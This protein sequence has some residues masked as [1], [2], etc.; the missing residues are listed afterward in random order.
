MDDPNLALPSDPS[1]DESYTKSSRPARPRSSSSG[2]TNA[3]GRGG[4]GRARERR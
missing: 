2:G 3:R 4:A 1:V